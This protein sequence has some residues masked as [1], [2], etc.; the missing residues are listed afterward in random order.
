VSEMT[1]GCGRH[2]LPGVNE[3][4]ADCLFEEVVRLTRERDEAREERARAGARADKNLCDLQPAP[5]STSWGCAMAD[6]PF[7]DI[8]RGMVGFSE[9]PSTPAGG[10]LTHNHPGDDN[11]EGCPVCHRQDRAR[12]AALEQ[13]VAEAVAALRDFVGSAPHWRTFLT[14][15]E[16]IH[17]VG[18]RLFD[19]VVTDARN[20]LETAGM[21]ETE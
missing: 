1:G 13:Q 11:W 5:S 17:A 7:K 16:R 10:A 14:T 19:D 9:G 20:L 15:R 6:K 4:C 21:R 12:I 3:S 8:P 18:L 2:E